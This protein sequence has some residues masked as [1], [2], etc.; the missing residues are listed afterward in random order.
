MVQSVSSILGEHLSEEEA[1]QMIMW[2][3][4][5]QSGGVTWDEFARIVQVFV[6]SPSSISSF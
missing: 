4:T 6:F 1:Q 5:D 3:D 2:A